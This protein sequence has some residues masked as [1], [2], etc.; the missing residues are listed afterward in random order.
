MEGGHLVSDEVIVDL[1]VERLRLSDVRTGFILDGF[2]C[3]A[4]RAERL[5]G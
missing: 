4:I 2:P 5:T 1:Q 3:N